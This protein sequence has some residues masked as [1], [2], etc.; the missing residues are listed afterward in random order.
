MRRR[1]QILRLHRLDARNGATLENGCRFVECLA[2]GWIGDIDATYVTI[3]AGSAT[4][5]HLHRRACC[6]VFIVDGRAEAQLGVRRHRVAMNDFVLIS[7]GVAHS[8]RALTEPVTLLSIHVPALGGAEGD[9]EFVR[10]RRG[11]ER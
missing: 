6:F 10:E 11:V 1:Y 5:P 8:F 9:L 3:P 4:R 2:R 7:P